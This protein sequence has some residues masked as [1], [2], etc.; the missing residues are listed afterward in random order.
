MYYCCGITEKGLPDHNE[1]AMLL[2]RAVRTHGALQIA[3][4]APFLAAVS[5]GVSGAA[6]GEIAS[7][8]CLKLLSAV[9]FSKKVNLKRRILDIHTEITEMSRKQ[10]E[11]TNMQAT[12]CGFGIDEAHAL[13]LFN[14]GDSRL[15]R[16]RGGV[17]EQLSRDQTLVQM[18]YEEGTLTEDEKKSHTHRHIVLSV[19][20][21]P[22]SAPKPDISV[23]PQ[24]L[25]P[26]EL[27]LAC[28]DGLTEYAADR[29]IA[30][31]LAEP[32][33]LPERLEEL[34]RLALRKGARDN[35]T[36]IAAV[37]YPDGIPLPPCEWM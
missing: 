9:K 18:L 17:L 27:L 2:H 35:I 13:H 22:D 24:G 34:V 37:R 20:G 4:E 30:S 28:T 8:T 29:E 1:D 23:L 36:I 11:L 19:M 31:V 12:L 15:Y 14:V 21:N 5:D 25:Q 6:A 3:A 26:G 10:E 7:E 32:M 16:L 33:P